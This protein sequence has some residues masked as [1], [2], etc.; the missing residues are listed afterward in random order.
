MV[1]Q[2]EFAAVRR[3]DNVAQMPVRIGDEFVEG[4]RARQVESDFG[5]E[6]PLTRDRC[7]F[8]AVMGFAGL[9]A[10]EADHAAPVCE[11]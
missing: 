1:D 11:S 4:N 7:S 5:M 6:P 9:L 3:I 10:G 8:K 2:P